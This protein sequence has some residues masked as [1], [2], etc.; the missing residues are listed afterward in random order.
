LPD[1]VVASWNVHSGVDGWGR[2][3][4]VLAGCRELD[5]DILVL[6]ETWRADDGK[7]L[8]RRVADELGYRM[9]EVTIARATMYPPP[10]R[11][12]TGWGPKLWEHA[13]H[14]PRVDK[15]RGRR[16]RPRTRA[17]YVP[18][19]FQGA[20]AAT[21]AFGS[22][23]PG[24]S[25]DGA[26]RGSVGL[27]L[28]WRIDLSDVRIWDLGSHLR[29]STSRSAITAEVVTTTSDD[30]DR[31]TLR[32]T[33]THLS[34]LSQGSLFQISR[35]RKAIAAERR[36]GSDVVL[37]GDMNLQGAAISSMLP[38]FR[39]AVRGRTW[40]AWKPLV[41]PDHVLVT[42][43]IVAGGRVVDIQG[44]DHLPLRAVIRGS[45]LAH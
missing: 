44:S 25:T 40:P 45:G 1:I 23:H 17:V 36:R 18:E 6:Q 42:S 39:R 11:P 26:A 19:G 29:D 41:Q 15:I 13:Y 30:P 27:A 32:V 8:S 5:A 14:G 34:H 33:A 31:R 12:V 7:S 10:P 4:D 2:P 9:E 3:F 38:G 20:G 24:L 35:L 16:Q 22:G 37:V 21:G 43:P 28:L